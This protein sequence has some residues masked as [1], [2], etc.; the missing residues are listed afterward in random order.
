MDCTHANDGRFEC[1]HA[2]LQSVAACMR[3]Q[4]SCE[5]LCNCVRRRAHTTRHNPRR[6][7]HSDEQALVDCNPLASRGAR[8][9]DCNLKPHACGR[10]HA[11]TYS[12]QECLSRSDAYNGAH[13]VKHKLIARTH[14]SRRHLAF[15]CGRTGCLRAPCCASSMERATSYREGHELPSGLGHPKGHRHRRSVDRSLVLRIPKWSPL[16]MNQ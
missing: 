9:V 15:G 7:A 12:S 13:R 10:M 5:W 14:S 4:L 8:M 6:R 2:G 3:L 11:A 1:T 16:F